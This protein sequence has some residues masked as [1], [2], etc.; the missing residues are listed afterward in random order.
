M[1]PLLNYAREKY[2]QAQALSGVD[3]GRKRTA[4]ARRVMTHFCVGLF[5]S[6]I[7]AVLDCSPSTVYTNRKKTLSPHENNILEVLKGLL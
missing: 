7:A 4:I 1:S 2:R 5:P 6:Q 3:G